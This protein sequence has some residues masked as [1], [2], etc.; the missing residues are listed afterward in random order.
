MIFE[1]LNQNFYISVFQYSKKLFETEIH[2]YN[3][4][5]FGHRNW[6]NLVVHK[7]NIIN[8]LCFVYYAAI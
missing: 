6:E 7:L 1:G 2:V 8:R 5:Y 3:E 4:Q